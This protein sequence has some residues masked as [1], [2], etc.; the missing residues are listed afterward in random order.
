MGDE[1]YLH[2]NYVSLLHFRRNVIVHPG[3][4]QKVIC[5]VCAYP[6]QMFEPERDD[7]K[8]LLLQAPHDY[9]ALYALLS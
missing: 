6:E 8:W 4:K 2:M 9:I 5:T 3:I 7:F 1:L